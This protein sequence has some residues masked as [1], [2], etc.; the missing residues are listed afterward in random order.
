MRTKILPLKYDRSCR[1]STWGYTFDSLT[2]LKFAVSIME[3]YEFIREP[4][5]IYYHPGT[6]M[7]V[8]QIRHFHR[9][10]TPDFLIRHR[11]T[12]EA[13]LIEIKPRCL[14]FHPQLLQ[15]KLVA[16]N[17]ISQESLD[18]TYKIIFDDEIILTA[19]QLEE[20]EQCFQLNSTSA[21]KLWFEEYRRKINP[22]NSTNLAS[23][24]ENKRIQFLMFGDSGLRHQSK[25]SGEQ[26]VINW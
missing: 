6:K 23:L 8:K 17:F 25:W 10:Y 20:F 21:W 1:I 16:E 13:F 24:P 19:D 18:W 12:H 2:E 11:Q 26:P 9:R 22:G 7:P 15:R 5:S 14:E 3:D 4:V